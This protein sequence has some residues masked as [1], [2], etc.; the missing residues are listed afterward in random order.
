MR[1][2]VQ[3]GAD[4]RRVFRGVF[5]GKSKK[6]KKIPFSAVSDVFEI[7]KCMQGNATRAGRGVL[8]RFSPQRGLARNFTGAQLPENEKIVWTKTKSTISIR[9]YPDGDGDKRIFELK[10]TKLSEKISLFRI[11][12]G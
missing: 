12:G 2:R 3:G 1:L 11:D 5:V 9:I 4:R 6:E 10:K 7:R 8:P